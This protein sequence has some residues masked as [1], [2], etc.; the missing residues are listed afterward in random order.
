MKTKFQGLNKK[1]SPTFR[2]GTAALLVSL[3]STQVLAAD[4]S[5][6]LVKSETAQEQAEQNSK[7]KTLTWEAGYLMDLVRN[8]SGGREVGSSQLGLGFLR[9]TYNLEKGLGASGTSFYV[10]LQATHGDDPSA[11]LIGD[12]QVVTNAEAAANT[13][14]VYEAY[15]SK[16]WANETSL[17][18]GLYD[19]NSEFYFTES[20][21]PFLNAS[22]GIGK[23][24]SQTGLNGPS[25]FPTTSL[26][27]RLLTKLTPNTYL[28]AAVLDASAGDPDE[29]HGTHVNLAGD[30]GAL[31]VVE[32]GYELKSSG[33]T[34]P[35]G[36]IALGA[37]R[38]TRT[39]DHLSSLS[40]SGESE[41]AP[42]YG[43]Y[44]LAEKSFSG[45]YKL[46]M[47]AGY[48]SEEVNAFNLD[49]AAGATS[50]AHFIGRP[51]DLL[52]VAFTMVTPGA[53]FRASQEALGEPLTPAEWAFELT[54]RWN[55]NDMISL[56]PDLQ[57]IQNP[58]AL[59][60]LPSALVGLLRL[61]VTYSN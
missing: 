19:L 20:S 54:Y 41:K 52:G 55:I 2:S 31:L 58:G 18:F 13:G 26:A 34:S 24:F 60:N 51:Q 44:L 5:P 21:S 36:K 6:D 50:A 45:L 4:P 59:S 17:L 48:A 33:A 9:G 8:L 56:Q 57:Y 16:K 12:A 27:L 10:H 39:F 28:Q 46:F 35:D 53:S 29:P 11:K 14:K 23:D 15:L 22:F 61:K 32:A 43:S 37:W 3:I 25:I 38:Y 49:L 40:A 30:D 7:S 42:S 1:S 47:R